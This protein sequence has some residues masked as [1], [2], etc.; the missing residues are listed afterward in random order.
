MRPI[1]KV[2]NTVNIDDPKKI[3]CFVDS[4]KSLARPNSIVC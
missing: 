3:I 2:I 4:I 1:F